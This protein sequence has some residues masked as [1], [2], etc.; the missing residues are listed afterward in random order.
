MRAPVEPYAWKNAAACPVVSLEAFAERESA[1]CCRNQARFL[2]AQT[3]VQR[4]ERGQG[5][6]DVCRA[7]RVR[8]FHHRHA[9]ARGPQRRL[10]DAGCEPHGRV[11]AHDDQI[12]N[13]AVHVIATWRSGSVSPQ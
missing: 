8:Q 9:Q 6:V 5:R 10:H 1:A 11:A 12:L 3:G 2:D 4:L 7:Q 13:G